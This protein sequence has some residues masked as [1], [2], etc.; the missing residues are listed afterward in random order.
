MDF[1]HEKKVFFCE[2][3]SSSSVTADI[4]SIEFSWPGP[5]PQGGQFFLIK[6]CRTALFL[7]RPISVA[8]RNGSALRFIVAARGQGSRELADLRPG[9]KAE[10]IGPL[11]NSWVEVA[12]FLDNPP[13]SPFEKPIALVTGGVGIAPILAFIQDLEEPRNTVSYDLYAGFRSGSFCLENLKPRSL[14]LATEDGSQGEKGRIP[15]F[16]K[17]EGYGAVFACGP[18]PML[19]AVGGKCTAAGVPCFVSMERHMACGVGAC[20]GCR[21]KTSGGNRSCCTDGP[22]FNFR[23]LSFD[24]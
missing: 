21:V 11:G 4:A 19:K 7:A 12:G 20:L 5:A 2:C 16:F 23:E 9:E 17:P 13:K 10:L 14:F 6:P 3:T 22:I 15:D 1:Q 24:D 18:E 8:G